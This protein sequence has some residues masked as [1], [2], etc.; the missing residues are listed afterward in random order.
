MRD[1]TGARLGA[2]ITVGAVSVKAVLVAC[3]PAGGGTG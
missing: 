2:I 3:V 1:T